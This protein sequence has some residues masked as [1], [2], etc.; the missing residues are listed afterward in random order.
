[1]VVLD[2]L[3]LV[4]I[5]T[6]SRVRA[7]SSGYTIVRAHVPARPPARTFPDKFRRWEELEGFGGSVNSRNCSLNDNM[8]AWRGK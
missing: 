1:M 2:A 8:N 4:P 5:S 3:V 7:V 6:A